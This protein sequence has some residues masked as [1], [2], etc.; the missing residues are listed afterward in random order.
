[1]GRFV[2]FVAITALSGSVFAA[3]INQDTKEM[4]VSGMVDFDGTFGTE[5]DLSLK[6]G[7]FWI[8]Y[9]EFGGEIGIVDNDAVKAWNA[10]VFSEYSFM[11]EWPGI[12]YIGAALSFGAAEV[13]AIKQDE[14]AAIGSFNTGIKYF[15][16][17]N[18]A[19]DTDLVF[20]IASAEVFPE[21]DRAEDTDMRWRIGL[22]FF[23]D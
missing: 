6:G 16:T 21:K 7:Y 9:L 19:L 13:E 22:R 12:P 3:N 17:D 14:T 8:D 10:G 1:M 23:W 5:I 15:V 2:T 11:L 20:S 18:V 4:G